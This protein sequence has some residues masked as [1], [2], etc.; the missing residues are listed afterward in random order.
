MKAM[1]ARALRYLCAGSI[2]ICRII[3]E[4]RALLCFAVLLE[5]GPQDVQYNSAIALMEITAVAD[6]DET[7]RRSVFKP[8]ASAAK[9]VVEMLLGIIQKA[10]SELLIPSIRSIGNL[11][12]TFR[13]S[14]TRFICPSVL[15]L[16]EVTS[17]AAIALNKFAGPDN[18]IHVNHCKVITSAG[19]SKHLVALIYFGDQMVQ[20]PSFI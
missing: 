7:L 17:E 15:L 20:I 11:A 16:P 10:D 18:F 9:A 3:T 12:R 4:S 14:K 2:T 8:T 6:Q 1:E 19:G 5:K 13:A